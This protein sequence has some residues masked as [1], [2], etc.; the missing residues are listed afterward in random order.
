MGVANQLIKG[1]KVNRGRIGIAMSATPIT[2]DLAESLGLATAKGALIDTVE[3]D[4]PAD[5]AG[6][7]SQDIIVKVGGKQ[8]ESNIDVVRSISNTAPGTKVVMSVWRKGGLKE[9]TVTVGEVPGETRVARAADKK[10][11]KQAGTPNR[12][13]L[14]VV[15]MNADERKAQK[16]DIGVLVSTSDGAAERAGLRKGDVILGVNNADVK[17]TSQFNDIVAKLDSKKAVALL[18]KRED[19]TRFVTMRID[20]K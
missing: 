2:K 14:V 8:I 6:M 4:S 19:Q 15:E 5:K 3:K 10:D 16:T 9:I 12:L 11:E 7:Q 20:S 13:G 1:G 17:S 18:V